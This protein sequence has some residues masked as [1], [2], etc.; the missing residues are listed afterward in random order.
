MDDDILSVCD[1]RSGFI[2]SYDYYSGR[3][4]SKF[5]GVGIE[6]NLFFHPDGVVLKNGYFFISDWGNNKIKV[7]SKNADFIMEFYGGK[8]GFRNPSILRWHKDTL[9]VL[10]SYN[11]EIRRYNIDFSMLKKTCADDILNKK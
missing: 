3:F 10:D 11:L 4:I 2:F 6:K 5:G 9:Y 1:W 7:F 8:E